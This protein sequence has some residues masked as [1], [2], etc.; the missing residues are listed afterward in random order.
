MNPSLLCN[1]DPPTTHGTI[2]G[3]QP[4][5]AVA[6]TP[7][8]RL[9]RSEAQLARNGRTR[10]L[11]PGIRCP[12]WVGRAIRCIAA[13]LLAANVFHA[14]AQDYHYASDWVL[15]LPDGNG[16]G[17]FLQHQVSGLSGVV[18][19]VTVTLDIEGTWTG[20]LYAYLSV[21]E[22]HAVLLNRVG[23]TIANPVGYGDRGFQV[24][25]DD[26]AAD[27]DIHQYRLSYQGA[28]PLSASGALLGTWAPDGRAVDPDLVLDT[29][30]RT[31]TLSA[32]QGLNPNGTWTLFVADMM[33]GSVHVLKRWELNVWTSSALCTGME[34]DVTPRSDGNDLLT[35]T[36]WV[37]SGR[38]VAGLDAITTPCEFQRA[39]CAPRMVNGVLTGGNGRITVSDWVQAGRYVAAL[40]PPTV[41]LGPLQA[42]PV[43]QAPDLSL[44][45]GQRKLGRDTRTVRIDVASFAPT[46]RV[47]ATVSMDALGGENALGFTLGYDRAALRFLGARLGSGLEEATLL[48]NVGEAEDGLLGI[49][50]ALPPEQSL[51]RG[52]ARL[53]TLDF[54]SPPGAA[55]E[56]SKLRFVDALVTREIVDTVAQ[57]LP[58]QWED[59]PLVVAEESGSAREPF[60]V[61][62]AGRLAVRTANGITTISWP[63]GVW[64]GVLETSESI[65]P[66]AVWTSV[67]DL[68]EVRGGARF[69]RIPIA[70]PMRFYRLRF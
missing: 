43:L 31:A 34:G 44:V 66:G 20:D 6:A 51:E 47:V 32:L 18:A 24:L 23:K 2:E 38:F 28:P 26:Y 3:D 65:G 25:F 35:V 40:D 56:Q 12:A 39:D 67:T 46:A 9:A 55:I 11:L 30:P 62:P 68:V 70:E 22:G 53:L 60:A 48:L 36:D 5:T 69:V 21:G 14:G 8:A 1:L 15:E 33:P 17:N 59:A 27:G 19:Q 52:T 4:L 42:A 49:A 64:G 45:S 61:W 37:Q 7:M 57:S 13:L 50:L 58:G 16:L 41:A 29:D 63:D 54:Q 10:S